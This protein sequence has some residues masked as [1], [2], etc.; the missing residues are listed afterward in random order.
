MAKLIFRYSTM[1]A[2]KSL[3][4]LK[5]AH[6]YEEGGK[7]VILLTSSLDNRYGMGK[8]ASR[9]GIEKPAIAISQDE[10]I[11]DLWDGIHRAFGA[12]NILV[13]GD[14]G[15][16]CILVDEAQFLT[17]KQ[18]L[19]LAYIVD[20]YNIPVICYGLKNDFQNNFFPGSEALLKQA[21]DIEEIKTICLLCDGNGQE[22]KG[23][24]VL[25]IEDGKPVYTGD[26]IKIG[27]NES[28]VPVCRKCYNNPDLTKI[29]KL[30]K[31]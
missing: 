3:D 7:R 30:L 25:R 14:Y 21:Q 11:L 27:G 28:Y 5:V 18:V 20:K 15:V 6:N 16:S 24:M 8:I 29:E 26:Q 2:G 9:I 1:G 17:E 31:K 19:D 12:C 22:H 4:I 13:S 23:T 10:N